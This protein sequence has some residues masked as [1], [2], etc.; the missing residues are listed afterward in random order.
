[1][2]GKSQDSAGIP[3]RGDFTKLQAPTERKNSTSKTAEVSSTAVVKYSA[4]EVLPYF[5][6]QQ[7]TNLNV[8]PSNWLRDG[9]FP[10]VNHHR[11]DPVEFSSYSHVTQLEVYAFAPE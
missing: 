3:E 9:R 4:Q 5:K 7:D 11:R 10:D 6:L 1:M 8:A 2:E